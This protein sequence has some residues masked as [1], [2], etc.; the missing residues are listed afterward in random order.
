MNNTLIDRIVFYGDPE[1]IKNPSCYYKKYIEHCLGFDENSS[2]ARLILKKWDEF[3]NS[4][5]VN[6][7]DED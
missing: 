1:K 3:W 2:N 4:V 5:Y 7:T 6:E